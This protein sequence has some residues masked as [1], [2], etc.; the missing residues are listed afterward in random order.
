MF[1]GVLPPVSRRGTYTDTIELTSDD[2]GSLI[3][4]SGLSAVVVALSET[5]DTTS[6]A[7]VSLTSGVVIPALGII[8][9]RFEQGVM[10]GLDQETYT[11][12]VTVTGSGDTVEIVNASLPIGD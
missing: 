4:L 6:V 11:L 9:W 8:Q 10:G 2:D 12:T 5:G 3:D 7:S 1:T